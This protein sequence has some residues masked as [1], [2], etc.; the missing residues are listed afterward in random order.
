MKANRIL[1]LV[2]VAALLLT[3]CSNDNE[4]MLTIINEQAALT[5]CLSVHRGRCR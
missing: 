3:S 2:A 5:G 4:R 1:T